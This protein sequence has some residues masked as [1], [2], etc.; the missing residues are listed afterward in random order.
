MSTN[1]ILL[2]HLMDDSFEYTIKNPSTL[3]KIPFFKEYIE[4]TPDTCTFFLPMSVPSDYTIFDTFVQSVENDGMV[5]K[6]LI[7]WDIETRCA[8][9]IISSL[10][11]CEEIKKKIAM[12]IAR[13][14]L[15]LNTSVLFGIHSNKDVHELLKDAEKKKEFQQHKLLTI[16]RPEKYTQWIYHVYHLPSYLKEEIY[17]QMEPI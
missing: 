14:F 2:K 12:H 17:H 3:M 6:A 1:T 16:S 5:E 10:L 15:T 4:S 13:D 8:L 9:L 11:G 7:T